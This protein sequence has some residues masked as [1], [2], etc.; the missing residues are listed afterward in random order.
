MHRSY[1]QAYCFASFE[2]ANR[3][4]ATLK[5]YRIDANVVSVKAPPPPP[6]PPPPFS[7]PF[8]P[9]PNIQLWIDKI[10]EVGSALGKES[11]DRIDA[12]YRALAQ[13]HHPDHGGQLGD[14]QLLNDACTWLRANYREDD[15]PF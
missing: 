11:R 10:L 9:S 14:M 6:P 7:V 12:G 4:V 2:D 15:V 5:K 8:T 13:E 3:V 1:K